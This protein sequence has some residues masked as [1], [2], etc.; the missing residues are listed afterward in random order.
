MVKISQVVSPLGDDCSD[1]C[2]GSRCPGMAMPPCHLAGE[3]DSGLSAEGLQTSEC[4]GNELA[5]GVF[6]LRPQTTC[7]NGSVSS[8]MGRTF[9]APR[10][11]GAP[12]VCINVSPSIK[13]DIKYLNTN[14]PGLSCKSHCKK[15]VCYYSGP[16]KTIQSKKWKEIHSLRRINASPLTLRSG[17]VEE[18]SHRVM[19]LLSDD[20]FQRIYLKRS[21]IISSHYYEGKVAPTCI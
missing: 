6:T 18:G 17:K 9:R 10:P 11:K 1:S 3:G 19:Y 8:C 14:R 5:Q 12:F 13:T 20:K 4:T 7:S 2:H 16:L 15:I 21:K